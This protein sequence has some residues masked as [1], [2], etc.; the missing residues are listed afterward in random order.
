MKCHEIT[1]IALALV[2]FIA[3][4]DAVA[5]SCCG[6]LRVTGVKLLHFEILRAL[7]ILFS[8]LLTSSCCLPW[9][10]MDAHGK[11]NEP[12]SRLS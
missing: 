11:S 5:G 1:L 6:A 12:H 9:L 3:L 7:E 10:R 2:S 8:F 4:L